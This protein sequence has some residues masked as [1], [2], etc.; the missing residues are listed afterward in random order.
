MFNFVVFGAVTLFTG[1]I[2]TG[3][4]GIILDRLRFTQNSRQ[5]VDIVDAL[6]IMFLFSFPV[7]IHLN[8]D[9]SMYI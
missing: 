4:G 8:D 3:V 1:I 6:K 9:A 7:C 2:G 5:D